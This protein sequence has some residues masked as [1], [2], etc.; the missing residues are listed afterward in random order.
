VS[1]K[2]KQYKGKDSD[3]VTFSYYHKPKAAFCCGFT[4]R[5]NVTVTIF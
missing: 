3:C 5:E 2:E 4:H 1:I